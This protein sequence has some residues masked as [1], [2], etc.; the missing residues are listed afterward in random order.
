VSDD[1]LAGVLERARLVRKLFDASI[2]LPEPDRAIFL[3]A[4]CGDDVALRAEVE[5]LLG[6]LRLL[7]TSDVLP[8]L[9]PDDARPPEDQQV[10]ARTRALPGAP[11]APEADDQLARGESIGRFVVLGLVGRGG[12]GEVYAAY[13]PELDRRVAV[14]LLRAR[15]W[16]SRDGRARLLREAQAI[17]KLSHPNVVVVYDV[18]TFAERVF[19]A[20]EF[21]EGGTVGSWLEQKRSAAEILDVF[22]AAGHGLA[23]AHEAGMV[24]RDFKPDNVMLTNAGHVR[25]T[26]F[27][28]A[29]QVLGDDEDRLTTSAVER[30]M[31]ESRTAVANATA[32]A[33]AMSTHVPTPAGSSESPVSSG[34]Y[35]RAKITQT[36]AQLGTPAYMAPEQFVQD[37]KTNARTDQ[38]SF[39]VALY[40]ALYGERPFGGDTMT[41]LKVAVLSG[42]IHQAPA[43]SK[44]PSWLRRILFRG[45]ST[46]P[47]DRFPSMSA[48]LA[49]LSNDPVKRRKKG[50]LVGATVAAM[51]SLV[52][53]AH[54]L[55]ADQRPLCLSGAAHL[56]GIW[57]PG[58]LD[59]D[60]KR[61]IHGAFA[62]SGRSYAE[63]AFGSVTRLFD[64]Y[65]RRWSAMYADACEATSVRGE[66]SA[67][68]LDLRMACLNE[69]L[70]NARALSDV[71][72]TADAKVVENAVSA[73]ATLPSLDRCADVGLLRAVVRPPE[74][75]ATR[76]RVEQLRGELAK[77][78]ALR[79]SGQCSRA[80]DE[81][82]VL[83]PAVREVGYRPL[84]ADTL[85]AAGLI[86]DFCGDIAVALERLKEAHLAASASRDDEVAA[87]TSAVIS[88]YAIN[89]LGQVPEARDWLDVA[90]GDVARLGRET[91][92]D[93]MVAQAEGTLALASRNYET[94]LASA[95]RAISLSRKFV[96]PDHPWTIA[97]EMNKGDWLQVAGR[98]EEA[99]QT[100]IRARDHFE[101]V[102]GRDHP[103]VG[104]ICSNE[105]E[106]LNTLGRYSEA[107]TEL[108]RS[109]DIFRGSGADSSFLGWAL[110]GFGRALLGLHQAPAAIAPLEEA[111]AIRLQKA[112][113]PRELAETRFELARALWHRPADRPHD[114]VLSAN[115][116][117]AGAEDKKFVA[118]IDAWLAT[119][120]REFA[121][122]RRER[123]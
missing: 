7:R 121:T 111:M 84:V 65:V 102:L 95:D 59:S 112:A 33:T 72:A 15:V 66:Q 100:D 26:D 35:L 49:A 48:L 27:G 92:V 62:R 108:E 75:A 36:G 79:D 106:L 60:R 8:S 51:L 39:C 117:A 29:R 44:V 11:R 69:R 12:M 32:A 34:G 96:G 77:M 88:Y 109:I 110:T 42:A 28:L 13:D 41:D 20:M 37:G 85:F 55:G 105:G 103:S 54:R 52:T 97:G 30:R 87:S 98:L 80:S 99:L 115:S 113:P 53:V 9:V 25:V 14:K 91:Q 5:E 76:R 4:R 1:A 31:K 104:M 18:G 114:V 57:E 19:I 83:I 93:S 78:I 68:V 73:V 6:S 89:R 119:T 118:E 61:T 71:F 122:S 81:A 45:L 23:A 101:R 58:A 56:A 120:R 123:I 90:R 64:E 70:G 24:H 16:R 47:D 17:A 94:A 40:E 43:H 50:A 22:L 116:R 86:G 46:H 74:D 67:D 2:E 82:S 63:Q 107:K 38:F 3:Q 21:I 10:F